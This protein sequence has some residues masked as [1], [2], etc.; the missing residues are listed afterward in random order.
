[1]P[2]YNNKMENN[3]VYAMPANEYNAKLAQVLKEMEEFNAPEWSFFVKTGISKVRP[4]QEKDFW[5]KRAAGILRQAYVRKIVG[6]NRLRTKYGSK[7]NR[8]FKPERF[9]RSGG[10][11]IRVIL[12]QGEAAG[13]LEK[14]NEPG[15]R[16]G[17]RLTDKGR[18]FLEAIK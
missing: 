2:K 15:K 8:G 1:M 11:I 17:R 9:K 5:H 13:F 10:K 18:A 6:V 3:P 4:P 12:Q 14:Y 7:K 16:A